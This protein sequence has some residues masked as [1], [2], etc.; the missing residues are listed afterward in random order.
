MTTGVST[1]KLQNL[2]TKTGLKVIQPAEI[3]REDFHVGSPDESYLPK[4]FV[5][6]V[7]RAE[8]IQRA[9]LKQAL[10]D[11]ELSV[12]GMAIPIRKLK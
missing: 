4:D 8:N 12:K 7:V 2:L 3:R 6:L 10:N 9:K 11:D 1:R 5:S